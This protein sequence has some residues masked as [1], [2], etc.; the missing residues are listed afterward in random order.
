MHPDQAK[1]QTLIDEAHREAQAYVTRYEMK[2]APDALKVIEQG[3]EIGM[4]QAHIKTLCTVIQIREEQLAA[5]RRRADAA[6]DELHEHG[7]IE[8]EE[9]DSARDMAAF[10]RATG[11]AN[12]LARRVA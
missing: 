3:F 4:L 12:E 7:L 11:A 8:R 6:Y 2:G 1:A 5:A 9:D 10:T